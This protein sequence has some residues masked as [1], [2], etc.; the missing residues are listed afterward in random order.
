MDGFQPPLSGSWWN[1]GTEDPGA[2]PNGL[3]TAWHVGHYRP[4]RLHTTDRMLFRP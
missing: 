4:E 1:I 2:N 3:Q